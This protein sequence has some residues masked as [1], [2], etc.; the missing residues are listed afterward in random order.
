MSVAGP[1]CV[2]GRVRLALGSFDTER[3]A[4]TFAAYLRTE[5]V[6][7]A[8]LLTDESLASL[9]LLVPDL[10][11]YSFDVPDRFDDVLYSWFKFTDPEREYVHSRVNSI[12]HRVR[13]VLS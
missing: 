9:G 1:G 2:F 6:Q 3:E 7:F 11:S 10:G 4:E 13:D 5:L 8:F 12:R